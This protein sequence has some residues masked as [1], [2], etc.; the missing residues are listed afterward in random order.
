VAQAPPPTKGDILFVVAAASFAAGDREEGRRL[1][2]EALPLN[3]RLSVA[4]ARLW[5]IP[6]IDRTI[7]ER[8]SAVIREMGVPETPPGG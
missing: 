8:R 7:P 2:N 1:M 6:Y 3:P 5:D 4:S